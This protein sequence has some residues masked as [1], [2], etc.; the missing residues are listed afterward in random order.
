MDADV[1]PARR[2]E[3]QKGG[4]T[5]VHNKVQKQKRHQLLLKIHVN[6]LGHAAYSHMHT[7]ATADG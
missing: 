4:L 2:E 7:V 5:L 1:I 3:K 6:T